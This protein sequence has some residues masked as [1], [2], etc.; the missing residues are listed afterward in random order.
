MQIVEKGQAVDYGEAIEP[1]PRPPCPA[2]G[3]KPSPRHGPGGLCSEQ[4]NETRITPPVPYFIRSK[5]TAMPIPPPIHNAAIP[6]RA[7]CRFI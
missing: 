5:S 6:R 2:D 7:F 3:I 1:N 4:I